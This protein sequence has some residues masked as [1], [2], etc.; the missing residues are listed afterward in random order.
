MRVWA[1]HVDRH[2]DLRASVPHVLEALLVVGPAAAH[3]HRRADG[4]QL[5]RVHLEGADDAAE[6]LGDVGEVGDAAADDEHLAAAA[7]VGLR[8]HQLQD[9]AGVLEGLVLRG[10]AGV[11]AVVGQLAAEAQVGDG[12]SIH[13]TGAAASHHRPH[14]PLAVEQRQL[15]R[16]ARAGVEVVDERLLGPRL[17]AE[18]RREVEAA[19]LG[20]GDELRGLVDLR[21]HVQR[22]DVAVLHHQRV[23]LQQR[24][25]QVAVHLQQARQE[26][27]D[28]LPRLRGDVAHQVQQVVLRW[29]LANRDVQLQ[30]LCVHVSDVHAALMVEHDDV[31]CAIGVQGRVVLLLLGVGLHGLHEEVAQGASNAL[32]SHLNTTT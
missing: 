6:G 21:G 5:L 24:E 32:H 27:G 16:R 10:R 28:R 30:R 19:P 1:V 23:D 17:A 25:V 15:Q 4:L 31:G 2:A 8:S 29:L 20:A 9:G 13:D 18:G 3:P 22:V 12:V 14:P 26:G 7:L 11:L